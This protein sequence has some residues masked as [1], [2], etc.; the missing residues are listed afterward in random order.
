MIIAPNG[1][2][3]PTTIATQVGCNIA[4]Q[5]GET[6]AIVLDGWRR[7]FTHQEA[8][9]KIEFKYL[10]ESPVSPDHGDFRAFYAIY[11]TVREADQFDVIS[12]IKL[13]SLTGLKTQS[14]GPRDF[15]PPIEGEPPV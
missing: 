2:K 10:C 5:Q 3:T 8:I 11:D 14:D 1:S 9:Q 7:T 6:L 15:C 12:S 4:L 13:Q